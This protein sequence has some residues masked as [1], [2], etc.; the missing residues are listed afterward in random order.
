MST[1][2]SLSFAVSCLV[3]ALLTCARVDVAAH[4]T[5]E[6][7]VGWSNRRA[8]EAAP[9]SV[10]THRNVRRGAGV[11]PQDGNVEE[12]GLGSF[13]AEDVE[14][15]VADALRYARKNYLNSINII[16]TDNAQEEAANRLR[17]Q[18]EVLQSL[19]LSSDDVMELIR[20][21]RG[22]AIDDL[23]KRIVEDYNTYRG[24]QPLKPETPK[25]TSQ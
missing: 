18:F 23:S 6:K 24:K 9:S 25:H 3:I 17:N 16:L 8:L 7:G 1:P 14:A 12:R 5:A 19:G 15:W 13:A 4:L 2:F 10:S 20:A 11:L 21:Q 22:G